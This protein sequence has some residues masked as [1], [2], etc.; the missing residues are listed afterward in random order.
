MASKRHD[1]S[2]L[3][4]GGET[5]PAHQ[6][7]RS[8]Q[9][10]FRGVLGTPALATRH[11][12]IGGYERIGQ[13]VKHGGSSVRV[14]GGHALP[15]KFIPSVEV[16]PPESPARVVGLRALSANGSCQPWTLRRLV[17][18]PGLAELGAQGRA[19]PRP[20]RQSGRISASA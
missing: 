15:D 14:P 8:S 17:D 9:Y 12:P 11:R 4:L 1:K 18:F 6:L 19:G 13:V 20:C 10:A 2:F 16:V 3:R 5:F 7:K